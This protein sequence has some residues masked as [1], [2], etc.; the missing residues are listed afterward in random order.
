MRTLRNHSTW[1]LALAGQG[2]EAAHL[3]ALARELRCGERL[4]LL[5][6]LASDEVADFLASLDIFVF[7]SEVGR[8]SDSR[9]LRR[10]RRGLPV[11][12]NDLPVLREVL[13]VDGEPC[14]VSCRFWR[15]GGFRSKHVAGPCRRARACGAPGDERGRRLA[16]RYPVEVMVSR[17]T[18]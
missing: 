16:A 7:P 6:E 9:L 15:P 2:T 1:H 3:V 17:T 12:A 11:V 5:G 10:R 13:A 4:H 8:P 14:A 18:R